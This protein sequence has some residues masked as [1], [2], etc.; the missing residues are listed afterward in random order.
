MFEAESDRSSLDRFED[1]E[2]VGDWRFAQLLV[3]LLR[4]LL[5]QLSTLGVVVLVATADEI[6]RVHGGL[7]NE[8]LVALLGLCIATGSSFPGR[9]HA[10]DPLVIFADCTR[11]TL[12]FGVSFSTKPLTSR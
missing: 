12:T 11:D 1:V 6:H 9:L 4:Q 5:E 7:V 10:L 2:N 8:I 3:F